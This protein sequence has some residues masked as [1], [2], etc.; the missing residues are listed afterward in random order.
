MIS[1]GPAVASAVGSRRPL[2]LVVDDEPELRE[3]L[4]EWLILNDYDVVTA[5]SGEEALDVLAT[6]AID[7]VVTDV[8]MPGLSGV[9]LCAHIKSD[10]ALA[11]T[12]VVILTALS[13]LNARVAGLAAGADDFF[14]KP[15]QLVELQARARSLSRVKRLHDE[16]EAK[17]RLLRTLFA[18]FVSEDVAAEIVRDPEK[19]LAPGGVKREVTVLFGDL[20]GFTALADGLD[21][22]DVVDI[23][24][25]Y[26]TLM[27]DT[28]FEFGGT[29]DKFRGDGIM[30][31]FGAPI[32]HGDDPARAVRCALAIQSRI[33]HERFPK[34]PDLRLQ[35]GIGINTGTAVVGAI[36][37]ERR[38][39]FTVIGGEVNIAARFESH[40]GPGQ[41]LITGRTWEHVKDLVLVRELGPLRVKGVSEAVMAFDVLDAREERARPA[42]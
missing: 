38:M 25:V 1:N 2:V 20:R 5:K 14:T 8:T 12:P 15:I 27:V 35:T 19:H 9:E 13:D 40:A 37:S 4:S 29:L 21:P 3:L 17:T 28:V 30:A 36:G 11:F 10:P 26:L 31:I 24:N 16:L 33:R 41:V 34:F 22:S 7:L 23:L 32:S 39:D 42:C 6:R 18:R